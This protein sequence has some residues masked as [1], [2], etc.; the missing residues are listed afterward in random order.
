MRTVYLDGQFVPESEAKLS[1]YDLSVMQGAAAFE[2]TRSFNGVHFKL[3][4]HLDRLA[5][6]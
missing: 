6:S 5:Q 2:M 4:E 3:R 1:I